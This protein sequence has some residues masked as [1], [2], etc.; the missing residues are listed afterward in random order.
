[1]KELKK[2]AIKRS[3]LFAA[4]SALAASMTFTLYPI[5]TFLLSNQGEFWFPVQ[6]MIWPTVKLFF[7]VAGAVFLLLML[8]SGS[9]MRNVMLFL[10]VVL[11][12]LSALER[13]KSVPIRNSCFWRK[14]TGH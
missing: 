4:V 5:I 8:F 2:K 12:V 14:A 7:V 6:S 1:M 9:K 3:I 10:G 11:A 13:S